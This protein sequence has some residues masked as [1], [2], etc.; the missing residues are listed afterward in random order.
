MK[1]FS[2]ILFTL[3]IGLFSTGLVPGQPPDSKRN[4]V[5][6]LVDDLGWKDLGYAGSSLYYTPHLDE[7]ARHATVFTQAYSGH[8]VCS[9][10]RA[11]IMTGRNP[12]RIGITDWIP[13]SSPTDKPLLGPQI[14]N[15]LPLEEKTIGEYFKEAGYKTFYAGKWHLGDEP[16]FPEN[17]GFD[18][19]IGGIEK[20]QPPGG[21]YVPYEN[22]KL[23]DGPS[24][25][26]LT[27][28]L[29]DETI[30]FIKENQKERFFAFLSYYTV[31]TPIQ[32]NKEDRPRYDNLS[33]PDI[34]YK[35]HEAVSLLYQ[36]N[37]DYASMVTAMDRNVG[38]LI[39][40]LK[41]MGL[42]ENTVFLFSSDNGGLST[43]IYDWTIPTSNN[44]LRGGKGWCYEGGIR[45][46]QILHI[47]GLS[48]VSSKNETPT[49]H[50]DILP[51]LW[52]AA[53]MQNH[54]F[55]NIDGHSVL[56]EEISSH[57]VLFWDY[58]HY[59]GSGWTPGS[60]IRKENWKLIHFYETDSVE[61]Y[62]LQSDPEESID[63]SRKFPE[64]AKSLLAELQSQLK[65]N[66][67]QFPRSNPAFK[68]H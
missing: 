12:T 68:S 58:P 37:L 19:N 65:S 27:D 31:H 18:I 59:H 1:K 67:A 35:E 53:G 15:E 46:P 66:N 38:K 45:I 3:I 33:I 26:Y 51:T 55:T 4:V 21:Y 20:G 54:P 14:R 36:N 17:Q 6:V 44:P 9:P 52:E 50:Q 29:T 32:A 47:P 24:G 2:L 61:L 11:A 41:E 62:N 25:E 30:H 64:K 34:T 49:V 57:R 48:V 8:P 40:S 28:R 16:F 56:G 60:A 22:P 43:L 63:V 39:S 23:P 42:W 5:V 10:S 7:L 13:G